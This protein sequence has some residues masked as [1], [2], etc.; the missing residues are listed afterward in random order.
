MRSLVMGRVQMRQD[1]QVGGVCVR[2]A[3]VGRPVDLVVKLV[4]EVV[5]DPEL[6]RFIERA[7]VSIRIEVAVNILE[8]GEAR[9]M[10]IMEEARLAVT[11][12]VAPSKSGLA[13]DQSRTNPDQGTQ[14]YSNYWIQARTS[15]PWRQS[16]TS[17][18][19]LVTSRAPA[20]AAPGVVPY[21]V[22]TVMGRERDFPKGQNA[23]MSEPM[24]EMAQAIAMRLLIS[25]FEVQSRFRAIEE[26]AR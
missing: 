9:V 11:R 23:S 5:A 14:L 1:T 18:I 7:V 10:R 8:A 21:H 13:A 24:R 3:G 19:A 12:D 26:V 4:Q 15:H 17:S 6:V 25:G 16:P 2:R 22:Y 20:V